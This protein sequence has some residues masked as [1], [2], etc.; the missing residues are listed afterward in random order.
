MLASCQP[1]A[2]WQMARSLLVAQAQLATIDGFM[3][4]R[5]PPPPAPP[6]TCCWGARHA[7]TSIVEGIDSR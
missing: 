4:T 7:A 2:G 5:S 3:Q 1:F 6:T